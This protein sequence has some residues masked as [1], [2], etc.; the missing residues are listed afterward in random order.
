MTLK[1]VVFPAPFGPRIARRSPGTSLRSTSRTACRPPKRRPTPRR[2]RT[3]SAL[4]AS[5]TG[6]VTYLL[7]D[8][9]DDRFLVTD[10]RQRPL[11][12]GRERPTRRRRLLAEGAAEGLVDCRDELDG[13]DSQVAVLVEVQLLRV[14]V[15]DRIAVAVELDVAVAGVE[16]HLVEC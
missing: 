4:S 13:P 10:P 6:W 14:L 8:T 16:L 9:V 3:G 12:A 2:R 15:L 5:G 7:N 11:L 1:S